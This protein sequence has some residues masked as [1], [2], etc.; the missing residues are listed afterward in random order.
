MRDNLTHT[1]IL[2]LWC[3]LTLALPGQTVTGTILG[4]VT[5]ASGYRVP[6]A[7]VKVVN[8]LTGETRVVMTNPEGDYIAP[9]LPVGQYGVETEAEGFKKHVREGITLAVNQ[10]ARVDVRLEVGQVSQEVRVTADVAL[11]D[12]RQVQIGGLVD[13]RRINDLPLNGR[14]VYS[15]VDL[16]PGVSG[17][18]LPSQPDPSTG[19]VLNVNGSRQ[20]QSSFLLDGGQHNAVF[21]NGGLVAPNPDTVEEFRLITSNYNAEYGRSAGGVVNVITKSG[22]NQFHPGFPF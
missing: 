13:I 12:A 8:T 9:A 17:S 11:V 20:M 21:R 10:N 18:T 7:A 2:W 4:T 16:L 1:W 14:N 22:T 3:S 15:L 5:D 6:G 19:S